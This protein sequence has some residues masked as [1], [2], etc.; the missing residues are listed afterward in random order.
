MALAFMVGACTT[1]GPSGGFA[2][3]VDRVRPAVVNVAAVAKPA[4]LRSESDIQ[5]PP[6]L[7]GTP[8]E[9]FFR[10]LLE[11]PDRDDE[12]SA[13]KVSLGSGFVIEPS[14]YVVTSFHV[15]QNANKIQITLADGIKLQARVVGQ[16]EETDIALLKVEPDKPLPHV[17]WGDSDRVR[18]GDWVVAVGNP[19]GLGGTV[20]AGIIS[21]RGRDIQTGR[22]D[23]Y[24]Q[25]DAPINRGNS[26]GPSFDRS[27]GV[28]GVNSAIFASAGGSIG[29]G[30]AVPSAL[31][32][33][34]LQELRDHGRIDRGWLGLAIQPVSREIADALGLSEVVGVLVIRVVSG[35]PAAKSGLQSGDVIRSVDGQKIVD[36]RVLG[37]RVGF[38]A[39]EKI[40]ML[41]IWRDGRAI[42]VT[43]ILGRT[44]TAEDDNGPTREAVQPNTKEE[45]RTLGLSVLRISP[46]T[47]KRYGLSPNATGVLVTGITPGTPAAEAGLLP[48]DILVTARNK[49]IDEP[50]E[51][52]A[53]IDAARAEGRK[54]VLLLTHRRDGA[55]KFVA[56][57]IP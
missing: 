57:P 56:V 8:L 30:F 51:L 46:K 7:R 6:E 10:D 43:T 26:G 48:G 54:A 31:A 14:G 47:Q 13:P 12:S 37:R 17:M 25:I 29:I 50:K 33:S 45:P 20:T 3:L 52:E 27:G 19:F 4:P 49:P 28:I 24:L 11:M 34:V 39:P 23:D 35:G 38:A 1:T 21:A 40:V 42:S 22:F 5:I 9:E 55:E 2:D 41:D 36:T 15:I 44:P 32:R 16:D 18:V 53:A